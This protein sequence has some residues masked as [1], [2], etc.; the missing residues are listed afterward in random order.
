MDTI[1]KI[2]GVELEQI[3]KPTIAAFAPVLE[4]KRQEIQAVPKKTFKYGKTDRHQLDIYFPTTPSRTGKL[5][6]LFFIYGGGFTSGDRTLGKHADLVYANVGAFFSE[7]GFVTVVPDYRLVPYVTYPG[8]AEDVRDAMQWVVE[9]T[10]KLASL[11]VEAPDAGSIFV[12]AQSVGPVHVSAALWHPGLMSEE[13]KACVKGVIFIGGAY[14]LHPEGAQTG[15]EELVD[16]YWGS[17]EQAERTAPLT[18]F[19]NIPEYELR[20]VPRI[21][22]VESENEPKWAEITGNDFYDAAK[23]R[24]GVDVSRVWAKGHN[25]LSVTWC[26]SS[27]Q[28][29]EWA[30]E[31][32]IWMRMARITREKVEG[33]A[34][35]L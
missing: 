4:E 10:A 5:P 20:N 24:R 30:E 31:A 29:E 35:G 16:I 28:A 6:I 14:H 32:V 11:S 26:L 2:E 3:I 15:Y 33:N 34:K 7:R 21:L 27:G 19:N 25:H 13:L 22:M 8:P 12:M 23:A 17:D 1:A 18:L 9:H